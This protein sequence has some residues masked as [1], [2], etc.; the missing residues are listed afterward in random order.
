MKQ[1]KRALEHI[2]KLYD[3]A[4]ESFPK[5]ESTR[6]IQLIRK[7]GM[8]NRLHLPREIS[9]NMCKEC[10]ALLIPGKSC[11]V[12]IKPGKLR[13]ITCNCGA[14]KRIQYRKNIQENNQE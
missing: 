11:R 12:R 2:H 8:R 6:Y 1:K 9:R 3:L 14:I 4:Q 7:Y 13:V 5:K 10:N